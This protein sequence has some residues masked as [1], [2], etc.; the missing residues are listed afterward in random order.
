MTR[1]LEI[2][3][4]Q[5]FNFRDSNR[6]SLY[7][8]LWHIENVYCDG[9]SSVAIYDPVVVLQFVFPLLTVWILHIK[10]ILFFFFYIRMILFSHFFEI[11]LRRIFLSFIKLLQIYKVCNKYVMSLFLQRLQQQLGFWNALI[12]DGVKSFLSANVLLLIFFSLLNPKQNI[13]GQKTN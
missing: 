2:K 5:K 7:C 13:A 4:T 6:V 10:K 3:Y 11:A 1:S 12:D 8:T 9:K